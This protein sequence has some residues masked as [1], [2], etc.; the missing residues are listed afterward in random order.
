MI[1]H[2]KRFG[3][4]RCETHGHVLISEFDRV[5]EAE[6][7][8]SSQYGH[9]FVT[10]GKCHIVVKDKSGKIVSKFFLRSFTV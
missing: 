10:D 1:S 7:Q 2:L 8:I 5:D 9:M 4:Y 6:D 3:I